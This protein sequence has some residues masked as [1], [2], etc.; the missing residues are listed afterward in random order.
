MVEFCGGKELYRF[1]W[2]VGTKGAEICFKFLIG[3]LGLTVSL[4]MIGSREANI[5]LEE[6]SE[7]LGEGRSE[8][9]ATVGDESIM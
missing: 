1:S 8:L 4:R 7:F 5:V 6:M 9:R 3:S 2:V